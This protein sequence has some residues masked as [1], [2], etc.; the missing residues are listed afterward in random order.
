MEFLFNLHK[1]IIDV[2]LG[3]SGGPMFWK[4]DGVFHLRGITSFGLSAACSIVG[5]APGIYT[6][7]D[8]YLD[9]IEG[10]VWPNDVTY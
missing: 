9:W 4:E 1:L 6:R 7:V 5:G 2:L 10:L 3:D 8:A